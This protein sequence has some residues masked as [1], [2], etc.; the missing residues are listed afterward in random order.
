MGRAPLNGCL[1]GQ[2]VRWDTEQVHRCRGR[3]PQD[4]DH[5]RRHGPRG[6]MR[7]Q[8]GGQRREWWRRC[9]WPPAPTPTWA[10][11]A[12]TRYSPGTPAA[13][14]ATRGCPAEYLRA[15]GAWSSVPE[16]YADLPFMYLFE[17][18]ADDFVWDGGGDVG[19]HHP[20]EEFDGLVAGVVGRCRWSGR[21]RWIRTGDERGRGRPGAAGGRS[22]ASVRAALIRRP[23]LCLAWPGLLVFLVRAHRARAVAQAPTPVPGSGQ[24]VMMASEINTSQCRGCRGGADRCRLRGVAASDGRLG[25]RSA[26]R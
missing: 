19:W 8:L 15:P 16:L 21:R 12:P 23:R 2:G 1:A 5:W 20:G 24:G 18:V 25:S 9:R 7:R 22:R 6:C 17:L 11:A 26:G 14:M 3:S 13:G 4:R 10:G